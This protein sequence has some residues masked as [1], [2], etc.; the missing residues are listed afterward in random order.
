MLESLKLRPLA[1]AT[2]VAVSIATTTVDAFAHGTPDQQQTSF[3]NC[4]SIEFGYEGLAQQS[5]T[6]A[7][8]TITGLDIRVSVSTPT[9]LL[10]SLKSGQCP[11]AAP[12][13]A[14]QTVSVGAG[15]FQIVHVDF[16]STVAVTP[17]QK[18]MFSVSEAVTSSTA[19]CG[20]LG[21]PPGPYADGTGFDFDCVELPNVDSYFVTY[22]E[23]VVTT[24]TSTTS[25]TLPEG[26][27]GDV[28][29]TGCLG[30]EKSKL[31]VKRSSN[32][33]SRQITWKLAKGDAFAHASLGE[34]I[35][36]REYSLCIYDETDS[37]PSL[38]T[39]LSFGPNAFWDSK[40]PKGWFYLDKT[41]SEQGV[42]KVKLKT[43]EAGKAG[44][45]VQAR[46]ANVP[47]PVPASPTSI[48]D[49]DPEVTVQ[50]VNNETSMCWSST[51]TVA[52]RNDLS[53]FS[54][55]AP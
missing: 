40:D 1:I 15:S 22:A 51:F 55:T 54:A 53:I 13:I 36:D 5:F 4:F 35:T 26:G 34:P 14:Q 48:F 12:V 29:A 9:E 7:A 20:V 44:V 2:T 3:T 41:G 43:G 32:E 19:L 23:S 31:L 50:L 18:Y 28:P 39:S 25:T 17:G 52:K 24:T 42:M 49:L 37:T 47:L 6:P 38:A 45:S 27:C 11:S 16:P 21:D 8:S 30:G 10:V 33:D 46:G